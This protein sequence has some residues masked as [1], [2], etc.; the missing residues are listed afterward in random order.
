MKTQA[1]WW[2]P[3]LSVVV[4]GLPSE[5]R[6]QARPTINLTDPAAIQAEANRLSAGGAGAKADRIA[7]ADQL[8]ARCL[9]NPAMS[10]SVKPE[11]WFLCSKWSSVGDLP[12]RT[13]ER[14]GRCLAQWVVVDPDYLRSLGP[15]LPVLRT[16]VAR[17]CSNEISGRVCASYVLGCDDWCQWPLKDI[18]GLAKPCREAGEVGRKANERVR[19]VVEDRFLADG[20]TIRSTALKDLYEV[21]K[22]LRDDTPSE[23]RL[24]WSDRVYRAYADKPEFLNTLDDAQWTCLGKALRILVKDRFATDLAAMQFTAR[25]G[26]GS[27]DGSNETKV[28]SLDSVLSI[29]TSPGE[30]ARAARSRA[31]EILRKSYLTDYASVRAIPPKTWYTVLRTTANELSDQ[32]RQ[33]LGRQLW[34]AYVSDPKVLATVA[35]DDCKGLVRGLWLVSGDRA[36]GEA[37]AQWMDATAFWSAVPPEDMIAVLKEVIFGREAEAIRLPCQR[38]TEHKDEFAARL[39]AFYAAYAFPFPSRHT[40]D[41]DGLCR[42]LQLV[43]ES[44]TAG[45]LQ[46]H[47][48]STLD[49]NFGRGES[50]AVNRCSRAW[51]GVL[52]RQVAY[53]PPVDKEEIWRTGLE[54]LSAFHQQLG[55]PLTLDEQFLDEVEGITGSPSP[56]GAG[57]ATDLAVEHMATL[58]LDAPTREVLSQRVSTAILWRLAHSSDAGLAAIKAAAALE[59]EGKFSQALAAY[60]QALDRYDSHDPA[61]PYLKL[62]IQALGSEAPNADTAWEPISLPAEA[63]EWAK[64]HAWNVSL[65]GLLDRVRSMPPQSRHEA[66]AGGMAQLAKSTPSVTVIFPRTLTRLDSLISALSSRS[67]DSSLMIERVLTDL[68][69]EAPDVNSLRALQARRIDNFIRQGQ[70]EQAIGAARL[71][72]VLSLSAAQGWLQA[73]NRCQTIMD[74]AGLDKREQTKFATGALLGS[75]PNEASTSSSQPASRPSSV[76]DNALARSAAD[77]IDK[78]VQMGARRRAYVLAFAGEIPQAC[79]L[80]SRQDSHLAKMDIA[81]LAALAGG[82][83]EGYAD[84]LHNALASHP[85]SDPEQSAEPWVVA[86]MQASRPKAPDS[87]DKVPTRSAPMAPGSQRA[88]LIAACWQRRHLRWAAEAIAAGDYLGAESIAVLAQRTSP[89]PLEAATGFDALYPNQRVLPASKAIVERLVELAPYMPQEALDAIVLNVTRRLVNSKEFAGAIDCL[90]RLEQGMPQVRVCKS[91][92][93]ET[94]R[95]VSL[96][97]MQRQDE[98]LAVLREAQTLA[99]TDEQR[100]RALLLTGGL[101]LIQGDRL[102]A[103][104]AFRRITS[105]YPQTPTAL[106][107]CEMVLY[108]EKLER[109]RS[110]TEP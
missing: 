6:A 35:P 21:I 57:G 61:R 79:D 31:L 36:A 101:C 109:H 46:T 81:V 88:G 9:G 78:D 26:S 91:T 86:L 3:V 53:A 66:W 19:E 76:L 97:Q 5:G 67:G 108:V 42:S 85:D 74:E 41:I 55:A 43:G 48:R 80:A 62:L 29:L 22:L 59:R 106:K 77:M 34:D 103:L 45:R 39:L 73:I 92:P 99:G 17:L 1:S 69:L 16:A 10:K 50:G 64:E 83:C 102:A 84:Y 38:L 30:G 54:E 14:L 90:D 7:F 25:L 105:E 95:A 24:L 93:L 49:P 107:A 32:T 82:G 51:L 58:F 15:E 37:L 56:E 94:L 104:Q 27:R 4:M 44:D 12:S 75:L 52:C 33:D 47:W 70:W 110:S 96:A 71:D 13:T 23:T 18:V 98:A 8:A 68:C 89:D 65:A 72:V 63:S 87:A 20:E 40:L 60:N 100:A 2:V 28:P 11:T